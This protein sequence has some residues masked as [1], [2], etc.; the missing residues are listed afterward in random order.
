MFN[1]PW[2]LYTAL[3][4]ALYVLEHLKYRDTQKALGVYKGLCEQYD[5]AL[6]DYVKGLDA[7]SSAA[8]NLKD[9]ASQLSKKADRKTETMDQLLEILTRT[10]ETPI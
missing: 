3:L 1:V 5:A 2:Y 10:K 7:F 4:I 8:N 6:K 9:S